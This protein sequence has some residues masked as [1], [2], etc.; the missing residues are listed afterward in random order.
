MRRRNILLLFLLFLVCSAHAQ[1][2][3]FNF[4]IRTITAG[5]TLKNLSDTLT[6]IR[7]ANFLKQAQKEFRDAGYEVQTLRIATS[8]LYS[9]LNGYSLIEALPFLKALD[10]IV[11]RNGISVLSIGQLL[12]PQEYQDDIGDW[13]TL[14]CKNTKA[15]SFNI[16]ISSHQQGIHNNSIKAAANIITSLSKV[17]NGEANFRFAAL[18]NCPANIPFFPAAF[19]EGVNSFGIGLETPNLLTEAFNNSNLST[20]K[21]TVKTV[22]EENLKPV[23]KLAEKISSNTKWKYDGIDASPAPGLDASIGQA[24]ETYTKQPFG[25]P[26]TLGACALITDVLKS[27]DIKKCGYSGLMLPVVEDRVLAQRAA[28]QRYTVQEL[29]LYSSVSGTGLDVVPIPGDTPR[30]VIEGVL[31]DVAAL[32]LKYMAKALSVR[33][34]P[35]PNKKAG[36]KVTFDNPYLTG[37]LVMKV[38]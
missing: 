2:R 10:D 24:I 38:D 23:E 26:S 31:T 5:V 20:A 28:E 33:L 11:T 29:L 7:A 8:N 21:Q 14:L 16:S 37:T 22:L 12:S 30:A 4:R 27:L 3:T 13:A 19:H 9:W 17:S 32:S 6:I 18:A 35:I 1:K 34:F 36:E 15:I 25:S